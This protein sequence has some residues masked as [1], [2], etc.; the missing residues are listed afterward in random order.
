[1]V[2][3][4][5][6]ANLA[7]VPERVFVADFLP[8][9]EAA[10]RSAFVISNGGSATTHQA[11]SEG[12]PVLGIA[13][14]LDQYLGMNDVEHAGAGILLR[15]GTLCVDTVRDAAARA[16]RE[17]T[18]HAAARRMASELARYDACSRFAAFVDSAIGAR[19]F[20]SPEP[21]IAPI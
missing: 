4:A 16:L 9:N 6:R 21:D 15:A 2:A 8:G 3:T 17:D 11:L 14:N 7:R 20:G 1:M 10:R 5:G 19:R 12:V 13:S 18:L